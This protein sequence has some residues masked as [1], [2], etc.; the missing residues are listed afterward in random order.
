MRHVSKFGPGRGLGE[1]SLIEE[2][3]EP[4]VLWRGSRVLS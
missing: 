4:S 3:I 1:W 2:Y